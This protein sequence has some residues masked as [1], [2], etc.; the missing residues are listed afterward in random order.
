[1]NAK[2]SNDNTAA[3][4]AEHMK[5][6]QV[7]QRIAQEASV[8]PSTDYVVQ[9]VVRMYFNPF[10]LCCGIVCVIPFPYFPSDRDVC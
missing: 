6:Y 8:F 9:L 4:V 7:L 10:H 1:M 3:A 5:H 2:D